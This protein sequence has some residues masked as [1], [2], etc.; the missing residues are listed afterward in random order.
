MA[1]SK[2][3]F[4]YTHKILIAIALLLMLVFVVPFIVWYFVPTR[5]I[6]IVVID[7]T[8]GADFREHRSF[9]WLMHHW[10]YTKPDSQNFYNDTEDFYGFFP[11]DSSYSDPSQLRLSNAN[12]LYITDTYGVYT[13]PLGYEKFEKML[14]DKYLPIQLKY[15]GLTS[16]ELDSIEAFKRSGGMS[17]AEFNTLQD[18]QSRDTITQQRI[19]SIFGVRYAGALGKY[20]DDL[21]TA[22]RWMKENYR[23]SSGEPWS[24]SGRGIIITVERAIGDS[25]PG[26]IVLESSDL[27]L[28]PVVLRNSDHDL[29]KKTEDKVPYFYFF[30]YLTVD[31]SA[32]VIAQFEMQ[33]TRSGKEKVLSAGLSLIFPA[34]VMSDSTARNLYFAGDFA[35]NNVE[36]LLTRYW[37]VEYLLGKLFSF[38]FVSDQTR[39]FWKFYLPL[40][41]EV[42]GQSYNRTEVEKHHY[43]RK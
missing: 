9:F 22:P 15:G 19:G 1:R 13:Y 7:K 16:V 33:C 40:M 10:K 20:Y 23:Q 30:E 25:K 12:L 8:T 39:F 42:L 17:I 11:Q 24:Y 21:K 18:P 29:L 27:L 31:S 35:D 32:K 5:P 41:K 43:Q 36:M 2:K 14:S 37:N 3:R 4:T 6:S 38:Y 26:L 34:V 28:S